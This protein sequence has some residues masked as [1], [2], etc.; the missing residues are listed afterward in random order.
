EERGAASRL[1]QGLKSL[2]GAGQERAVITSTVSASGIRS[3]ER[4]YL[5]IDLSA[6]PAGTYELVL[7]ATDTHDGRTAAARLLFRTIP[8]R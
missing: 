2:V 1:Y 8:G 3:D 5:Q 7:T 6:L 4:A